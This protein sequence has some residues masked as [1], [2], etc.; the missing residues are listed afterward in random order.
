VA[1]VSF[2]PIAFSP[3]LPASAPYA[4]YRF[5]V[6]ST[7]FPLRHPLTS[8]LTR[9]QGTGGRRLGAGRSRFRWYK[10]GGTMATAHATADTLPHQPGAGAV[11]FLSTLP[12]PQRPRPSLNQQRLPP[13]TRIFHRSTYLHTAPSMRLQVIRCSATCRN[14]IAPAVPITAS[15]FSDGASIPAGFRLRWAV[16][17][18]R[19]A[20][21]HSTPTFLYLSS[22]PA[23]SVHNADFL[24]AASCGAAWNHE[25]RDVALKRDR[26]PAPA[27][28]RGGEERD[29]HGMT[30][31]L[32]PWSVSSTTTLR[33]G[34]VTHL[35]SNA[36]TPDIFVS[37]DRCV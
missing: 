23:L 5:A 33:R 4:T 3:C 17:H 6:F 15:R 11:V 25:E 14:I 13:T 32:A 8:D 7:C 26:K 21:I 24:C 37:G 28:F 16:A 18:A 27:R 22:P 35:L 31:P 36:I 1:P 9:A 12:T 10:H 34:T 29:L 19:G 20:R 2:A 30:S